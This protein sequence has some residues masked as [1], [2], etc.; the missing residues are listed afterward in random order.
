MSLFGFSDSEDMNAMRTLLLRFLVVG[1][2]LAP[3]LARA[4]TWPQKTVR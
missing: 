1:L 3:T 2:M 4:Q